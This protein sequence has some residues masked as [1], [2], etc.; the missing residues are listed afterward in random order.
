MIDTRDEA[1]HV[2]EERT[3]G[4]GDDGDPDH[5]ATW[6]TLPDGTWLDVTFDFYADGSNDWAAHREV[7]DDG[8]VLLDER[9]TDGDGEPDSVVE[10]SFDEEGRL[11]SYVSEETT[12]AGVDRIS[13]TATSACVP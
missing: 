7:D 11:T 3:V 2:T 4:T 8:N 9:D 10:Q 1:E 6:E 13:Y 12:Q 5:L